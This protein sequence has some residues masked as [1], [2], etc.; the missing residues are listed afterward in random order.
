[1]TRICAE[2]ITA[3]LDG[4]IVVFLIGMRINRFW[5]VH[6]WLP[7]A[8]AMPRMIAEL[9]AAPEHGFLGAEQ[10][11]GNPTIM[12]QYWRSFEELER[13]A[14]NPSAQH[15]P[16]W[17]AFN[18]AVG[19]GGDVGIWHETYR[20]RPG[21]YE[22]IYNNTPLFGLAKATAAV[23]A[24]GRFESAEGRMHEGGADRADLP[25]H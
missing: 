10:W 8:R 21:D 13:Y 4:E 25:R 19:S 17:A 18:R 2:R 23:P 20:V 22:C 9:A 5:K 24:S 11:L 6:K 15:L 1:M 12:L 16:A 14:K 7:V 3:R